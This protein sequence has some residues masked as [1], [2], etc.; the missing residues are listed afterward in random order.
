MTAQDQSPRTAP[1]GEHPQAADAMA[2]LQQFQSVLDGATDQ[3]GN[4]T[5][6]GTDE[7]ETVEVTINGSEVL[8]ALHI[9]DG[10]LRLGAETVQH[11]INEALA[12]AQDA[13]TAAVT[14]QTEQLFTNLAGI[15]DQ[16]KTSMGLDQKQP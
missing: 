2:M 9:E 8:T 7:E 12:N 4:Q 6:T 16:L 5:F 15:T 1:N 3:M 13:A 10:L 14:A 11:R